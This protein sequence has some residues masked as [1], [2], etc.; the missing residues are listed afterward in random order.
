MKAIEYTPNNAQLAGDLINLEINTG[1]LAEAQRLI[2]VAKEQFTDSPLALLAEA[3]LLMRKDQKKAATTLL[4]QAWQQQKDPRIAN[5]LIP[6]YQEQ[7]QQ[8]YQEQSQQRAELISQW[9]ELQPEAPA[10]HLFA[11]TDAQKAGDNDTAI[12]HY[13]AIIKSA[14]NNVIALNNLA[15]LYFEAQ[16]NKAIATAKQAIQAAPNAPE[17]LD[18]YGWIEWNMGDKD[19]GR[20]ALQKAAELAP[21]NAEIK[22]HYQQ[23]QQ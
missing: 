15:W 1:N 16:N 4:E 22:A 9:L 2:A 13:E 17:V 18:T 11:A 8:L 23:T 19:D 12:K 3:K 6:L 21:D 10:P 5:A 14:P 7:S 20:K